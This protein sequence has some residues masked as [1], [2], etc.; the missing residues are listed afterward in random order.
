MKKILFL[1]TFIVFVPFVSHADLVQDLQQ[2]I[3]DKQTERLQLQA[4]SKLLQQQLEETAKTAETLNSTIKVLDTTQKKLSTDLKITENNINTTNLSINQITEKIKLQEEQ[5]SIHS[6]AVVSAIRQISEAENKST[7]LMLLESGSISEV[8]KDVDTLS[9]LQSSLRTEMAALSQANNE[10]TSQ[11]NLKTKKK[12]E[13]VNFKEDLIVKKQSVEVNKK[14]KADLL[15]VTKNQEAIYQKL[16]ADNRAREKQFEDELYAYESQLR[17]TIDPSLLPIKKP[18]VI[19]WPLDSVFITQR[20]G[21]TIG[22]SR[23]YASGSHNGVDFRATVGTPVKAVLSGT[24]EGTGNTDEQRGCYSYGRWIL[25]KHDN[26]LST[27][28][29]HLSASRVTAGQ[30]VSTGDIIGLSGG[31]PG[32][33]GSGYSTGQHLH[34]GLFAS[35]GVSIKQ[36]TQSRGCK[37]ISLPIAEATAYLDPLAYLPAI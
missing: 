31:A 28:Y 33:F 16:L 37:Q 36:F 26:G 32:M 5:I 13:L 11:V 7:A 24:I 15:V 17:I 10:L 21:R 4:Q 34:L 23:L 35:Q 2:K 20:F 1:L 29:G 18:G 8:W 27:I 30:R 9:S 19:D 22:A 25:I 3:S 14:S 6:K 12:V